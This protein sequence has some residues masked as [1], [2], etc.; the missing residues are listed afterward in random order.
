MF[1]VF[2]FDHYLGI[3]YSHDMCPCTHCFPDK[4]PCHDTCRSD[5]VSCPLFRDHTIIQQPAD[6]TTLTNTYT[7]EAVKFIK[8][9]S[10]FVPVRPCQFLVHCQISNQTS[11]IWSRAADFG[12]SCIR[13]LISECIVK[14]SEF[15]S[16][17]NKILSLPR[18]PPP[19]PSSV[20]RPPVLQ[21]VKQ[22][23]FRR[24]FVGTRL[25]RWKN[26]GNLRKSPS[27]DEKLLMIFSDEEIMVSF[28]KV[29]FPPQDF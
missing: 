4:K 26:H 29:I 5:T 17:W 12:P 16:V 22:K 14:F 24:F 23:I 28:F 20:L 27:K 1:A 2:M 6:L 15:R 8:V 25:V 3:P 13:D 21:S 7:A 9:S 19:S 10:I 18:L 11:Q